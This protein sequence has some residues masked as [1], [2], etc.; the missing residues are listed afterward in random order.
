MVSKRTDVK[1][2]QER[3]PAETLG[4][5]VAVPEMASR[6]RPPVHSKSPNFSFEEHGQDIC[7]VKFWFQQY[8]YSIVFV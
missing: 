6:C 4:P 8:A 3:P 1:T 2:K 5:I 7:H